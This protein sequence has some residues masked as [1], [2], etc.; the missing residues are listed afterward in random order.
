MKKKS[1]PILLCS[2]FLL[3]SCDKLYTDIEKY[4]EYLDKLV[5]ADTF[6]PKL[7]TL[8]NYE[9]IDLYFLYDNIILVGSINLKLSYSNEYYEEE[10]NK[11]LNLY[12]FLTTPIKENS[13]SKYYIIP[14]VSFDYNEYHIQV[15]ED[16]NYDY[17][18][19]FG[20]IGYS[21]SLQEIC[22]LY[23]NNHDAVSI[24][25]TMGGMQE[26]MKTYFCFE[27]EDR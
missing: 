24:D 13:T 16:E 11:V 10:K 19:Y 1:L 17:N 15:V 23:Y 27:N 5:K 20:M 7:D 14:E 9:S 18:R 12:Q 6:M 22:Y 8:S 4:D 21:D 2:L 25:R 26:L 3:S